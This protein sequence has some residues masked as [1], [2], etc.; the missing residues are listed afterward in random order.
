[1]LAATTRNPAVRVVAAHGLTLEEVA[2]P[3]D[4]ELAGQAG[5]ARRLRTLEDPA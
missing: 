5:A 1:V 4:V 3:P 2:Y